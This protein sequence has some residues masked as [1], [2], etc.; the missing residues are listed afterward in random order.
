MRV[1]MAGGLTQGYASLRR[2]GH[3]PSPNP[4][5]VILDSSARSRR[6]TVVASRRAV[7]HLVGGRE[8]PAAGSPTLDSDPLENLAPWFSARAFNYYRALVQMPV[9]TRRSMWGSRRKFL[10]IQTAMADLDTACAHLRSADGMHY[11]IVIAEGDCAVAAAQWAA[12]RSAGQSAAD[13]LILWAPALPKRPDWALDITC[14]VLVVAGADSD[15]RKGQRPSWLRKQH[16]VDMAAVQLGRRVTLLRLPDPFSGSVRA[17]RG[18][19]AQG[20]AAQGS[21]AQ[22]EPA[23]SGADFFTE[24]GRWLGAYMYGQWRDQLL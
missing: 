5:A 12:V 2:P 24:L 20:S 18:S 14:P 7:L 21:D 19:D 10:D 23:A 13:A 15:L 9:R 11:I 6:P 4:P 17:S 22:A 8:S 3:R 16:R 1:A